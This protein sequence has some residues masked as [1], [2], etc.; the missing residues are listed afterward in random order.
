M[1]VTLIDHTG[2][3]NS[4]PDYAINLLLFTKNTR[5]QMTPGLL[6][7]ISDWP[8][9]KKMDEL[10]YMANT[11]PS[12]W[13]FIHYTFLMEDVTRAFT[14][15][16]VRTRNAS[17]AQQTMRVLDVSQGP[18]W[19]YAVGP[20]IVSKEAE[21]VY[22]IAM[23]TIAAAYKALVG[24]GVAVSDA[25]GLL[26]TNILTNIIMTIN[27]RNF[28]DMVHKRSGP[29]VQD[30]YRTVIEAAKA[31]ALTVHPWLSIFLERTFDKAAAELE[32]SISELQLPEARRMKLFKLVDQMKTR[33][34]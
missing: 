6:E 8:R 2:K 34:G 15:Q 25:R 1:K 22:R 20:S 16:L 4:D 24:M 27:M 21:E 5:L 12:S 31:A 28:I 3:G 7:E 26:P 9:S 23:A 10:A 30:E 13:E 11:I 14:H 32:E 18:G 17:Y 33:G 29:R 19:D